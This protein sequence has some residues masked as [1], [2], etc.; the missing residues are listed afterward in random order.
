MSLEEIGHR[1]ETI[2]NR[3][4]FY[5]IIQAAERGEDLSKFVP[6]N[7]PEA[8][9]LADLLT[10][11]D[12]GSGEPVKLVQ[13][14]VIDTTVAVP[15][16]GTLQQIY[17]NI[18]LS[19]EE[20][21]EIIN[22]ANLAFVDN[23]DYAGTVYGDNALLYKIVGTVDYA[24]NIFDF[25]DYYGIPNAYA[26]M[27][28][29]AVPIF[30]TKNLSER[31]SLISGW[32][33]EIKSLPMGSV[34]IN[35]EIE[36]AGAQNEALKKLV[37]SEGEIYQ[38]GNYETVKELSGDYHLE[39]HTVTPQETTTYNILDLVGEKQETN[40]VGTLLVSNENTL[41]EKIYF[42]TELDTTE[43]VSILS[44]LTYINNT[45]IYPVP[46]YI[47]YANA[48]LTKCITVAANNGFYAIAESNYTTGDFTPIFMFPE[49]N[50]MI[51]WLLQN[52]EYSLNQ[53]GISRVDTLGLDIG[54]QNDKLTSLLSMNND[55]E[56]VTTTKKVFPRNIKVNIP[57]I[58]MP[59]E[60]TELPETAKE[61]TFYRLNT[62]GYQCVVYQEGTL[63]NFSDG[64]MGVAAKVIETENYPEN[65]IE[66]VNNY[67]V[68]YITSLNNV[69][70]Y[71]QGSWVLF[72]QALGND[73]SFVGVIENTSEI[74]TDGAYL[75][76]GIVSKD[77]YKYENSTFKKLGDAIYEELF[78][79]N[80]QGTLNDLII[81]EGVTMLRNYAFYENIG[82]LSVTIPDSVVGAGFCAFANCLYLENVTIGNGLTD[83]NENMFGT[84]K[85]LKSVTIGDNVTKIWLA[86]FANCE[87]LTHITIPSNVEQIHQEVFENCSSLETIDFENNS[88]LTMIG[89]NAFRECNSL[90]SINIPDGVGSIENE[91]FKGC[92][93]L[94]SVNIPD[95]VDAIGDDAFSGCSSLILDKLPEN[96]AYIGYYAFSG[97]STLTT[98]L[99][100]PNQ[101]YAIGQYAFSGCTSITKITILSTETNLRIYDRA[102]HNCDSLTEVDMSSLTQV[103]KFGISIFE[104]CDVLTTIKVPNALLEQ[105]KTA[106]NMTE[107]AD[108]MVGV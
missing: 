3:Y 32:N 34:D 55:F 106:E 41:V 59:I 48:D 26:I 78:I 82:L 76:K 94:T 49:E 65:P 51:G 61:G 35:Q 6:A 14:E 25:S 52:S 29:N 101:V 30:I 2:M 67:T 18:N 22:N 100:I 84:C 108:L 56:S 95:N 53:T 17:F 80:A 63:T 54:D 47:I 4:R 97:C 31:L 99:I 92:S 104:Y 7:A 87:A 19:E 93:S 24:F 20:V 38:T 42:N 81:P 40:K 5:E 107:Y 43:V 79:G 73:L 102:F 58:G 90:K 9:L 21:V 89:N 74:K 103:P 70:V 85:A 88:K 105:F 28:Y 23:D 11:S 36:E 64:S 60:V 39:N 96:L 91:T 12:D 71:T 10:V 83:I 37:Y 13:P 50:G 68:Y 44:T 66:F 98:N 62:Y 33:P 45:D 46:F 57:S 27:L 16:S 8:A 75:L 86:A 72:N 69:Y 15:T 77:I 1:K